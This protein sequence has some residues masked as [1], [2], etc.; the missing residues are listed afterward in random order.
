MQFYQQLPP[1]AITDEYLWGRLEPL[2]A[3]M[4]AGERDKVRQERQERACARG[5]HQPGGGAR[6]LAR[7]TLGLRERGAVG[8]GGQGAGSCRRIGARVR[9]G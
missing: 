5:E 7:P 1:T 6:F 9:G 4:S 3:Y 8:A 2:L